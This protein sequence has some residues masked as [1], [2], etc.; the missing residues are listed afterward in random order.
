MNVDVQDHTVVFEG[1]GVGSRGL[2]NYSFKLDLMFAVD[3]NVSK[4]L[5]SIFNG[6]PG[7]MY[8]LSL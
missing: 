4:C 3:P 5:F 7:I 8:T 2:N 1:E 6:Q